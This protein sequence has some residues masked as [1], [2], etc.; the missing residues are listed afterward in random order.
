MVTSETIIE[1]MRAVLVA[2]RAPA[3]FLDAWPT[4]HPL[5]VGAPAHLAV[6]H[7]FEGAVELAPPGPLA[8]LAR[9]L[10]DACPGAKPTSEATS[11]IA[12]SVAMAG[13]K[14]S[15][16]RDRFTTEPGLLASCC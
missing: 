13:A 12:S 4:A 1:R 5:P 2:A 16:Q 7:W 10:R 3:K 6:L 8:A 11:T 9:A 15:V 14:S